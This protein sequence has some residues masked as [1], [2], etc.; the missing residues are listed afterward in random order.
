M[1]SKYQRQKYEVAVYNY[2]IKSYEIFE[3]YDKLFKAKIKNSSEFELSKELDYL[4]KREINKLKRKSG[5]K[6]HYRCE[7]SWNT[8]VG[9][10]K[11]KHRKSVVF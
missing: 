6:G 9:E 3:K 11:N 10:I 4:F 8:F 5:K 1:K 7:G 2:A